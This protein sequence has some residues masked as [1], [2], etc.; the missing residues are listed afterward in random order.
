MEVE[1]RKSRGHPKM[2]WMEVVKK[3]IERCGLQMEDV[4]DRAAWRT[5]IG[6]LR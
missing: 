1:E 5:K 4:G 2:T 3:D 6:R